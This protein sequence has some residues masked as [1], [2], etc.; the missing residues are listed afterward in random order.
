MNI[1]FILIYNSLPKIGR[2]NVIVKKFISIRSRTEWYEK[3]R[4][5]NDHKEQT[6]PYLKR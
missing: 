2:I 4:S 6:D 3:N 5:A 1:S